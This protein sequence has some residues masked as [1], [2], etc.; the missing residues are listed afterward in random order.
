MLFTRH[1]EVYLVAVFGR[2][3]E[4]RRDGEP[5]DDGGAVTHAIMLDDPRPPPP[6]LRR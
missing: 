2:R 3:D 1:G 5:G 6:E 4:S